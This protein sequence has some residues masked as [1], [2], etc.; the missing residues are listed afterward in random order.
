MHGRQPHNCGP[1]AKRGRAVPASPSA[2]GTQWVLQPAR[3]L[4]TCVLHCPVALHLQTH[5][6]AAAKLSRI[7]R[8][9]TPA[10]RASESGRGRPSVHSHSRLWAQ[11]AECGRP[12]VE[13]P[14][15][16]GHDGTQSLAALLRSSQELRPPWRLTVT[17]GRNP[18]RVHGHA[19]QLRACGAPSTRATGCCLCRSL[20][21][22]CRAW[23]RCPPELLSQAPHG[24]PSLEIL[25]QNTEKHH[26]ASLSPNL[27]G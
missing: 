16:D 15:R 11:A 3:V 10:W 19:F 2:G 17:E 25:T 14:H 20:L 26:F 22:A 8:W 21:T 24:T 5:T 9:G 13:P 12:R 6:K 7:L 1:R 18:A 23:K 27:G 4:L